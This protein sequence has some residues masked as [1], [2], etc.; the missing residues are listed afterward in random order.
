M[1]QLNIN[2][3]LNYQFSMSMEYVG[4]KNR[5]LDWMCVDLWAFLKTVYLYA[6]WKSKAW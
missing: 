2:E 6:N 3:W 4:T 5:R 1:D